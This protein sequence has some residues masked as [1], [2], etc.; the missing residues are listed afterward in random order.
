MGR[1]KS[2]KFVVLAVAQ[3]QCELNWELINLFV[4][5]LVTEPGVFYFGVGERFT[6]ILTYVSIELVG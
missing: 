1:C 3:T 5:P 2:G 6:H 4:G